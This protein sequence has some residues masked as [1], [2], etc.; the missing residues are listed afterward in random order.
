MQLLYF[1]WVRT[2]IGTGR[3]TLE[4]PADITNVKS[5]VEWLK[6]RGE[7]YRE[8]LEDLSAIR[9]AVNQEMV[10][11]GAAISPGDEVALFPPMTGG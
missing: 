6:D 7:G 1:G 5:L 10:D 4:P 9:V 8:A 3:E 2:R 11:L